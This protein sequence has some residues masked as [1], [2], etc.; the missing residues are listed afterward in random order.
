MLSNHYTALL[1][2]AVEIPGAMKRVMLLKV[3]LRAMA[4]QQPVSA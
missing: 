2:S 4:D 3:A 1:F